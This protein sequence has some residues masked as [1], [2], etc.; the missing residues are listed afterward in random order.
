MN[1]PVPSKYPALDYDLTYALA[2]RN[3]EKATRA[4]EHLRHDIDTGVDWMII[5]ISYD[6]RKADLREPLMMFPDFWNWFRLN[7]REVDRFDRYVVYRH[8]T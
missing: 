4:T 3:E 1:R 8:A 2:T 6:G 5:Q 7:F